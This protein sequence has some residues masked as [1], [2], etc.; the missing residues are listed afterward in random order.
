MG[1]WG[2]SGCSLAADIVD[3]S[4][5]LS[6]EL[7]SVLLVCHGDEDGLVSVD[8]LIE[9]VE[10]SGHVCVCVC[11]LKLLFVGFHSVPQGV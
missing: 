7:E 5:V 8:V 1:E 4:L 2:W 11:L 3:W 10:G 6:S 9:G